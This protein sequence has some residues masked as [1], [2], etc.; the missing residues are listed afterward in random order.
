M[1]DIEY[2]SMNNDAEELVKLLKSIVK[3]TKARMRP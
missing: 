1:T 3:T 2:K